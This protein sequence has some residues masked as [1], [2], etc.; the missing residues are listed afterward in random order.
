MDPCNPHEV[1]YQTETMDLDE[2]NEAENWEVERQL[3]KQQIK[4]L[5][6]ALN[7][8]KKFHQKFVDDVV[9]SEEI[10]IR[11][12]DRD[13]KE[14]VAVNK[15]QKAEIRQL[16]KDKLF[17]ETT[18][19]ALMQ[20]K[21]K[22]SNAE[23]QSTERQKSS[24]QSKRSA[25]RTPK[26]P[27]L[28][29][30]SDSKFKISTKLFKDNKKLKEKVTKLTKFNAGLRLK[31]KQLENFKNKIESRKEEQVRWKSFRILLFSIL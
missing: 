31:V 3:L 2:S 6:S 17:Y 14:L 13:K 26:L 16:T 19:T 15:R 5:E 20:E 21:E 12:F 27:T 11:E 30:D 18:C 25:T 22:S 23:S 9:Q 29:S 4:E 10:R 1:I 8:S 24:I 7:K 28:G